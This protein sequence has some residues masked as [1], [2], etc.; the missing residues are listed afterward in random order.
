[1]IDMFLVYEKNYLSYGDVDCV[2]ETDMKLYD[3]KEKAITE[4]ERRKTMYIED[5]E[6][7]FTYMEMKVLKIVLLFADELSETGDD[8]EGEFHICVVELEVE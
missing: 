7:D 1:M 6:N 2:E 4:M 8:R 5:T 3:T